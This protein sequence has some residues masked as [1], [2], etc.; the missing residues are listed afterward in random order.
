MTRQVARALRAATHRIQFDGHSFT[1]ND[2]KEMWMCTDG[3]HVVCTHEHDSMWQYWKRE[4]EGGWRPVGAYETIISAQK[5]AQATEDNAEPAQE[6]T[7]GPG[8]YVLARFKGRE[9]WMRT[10]ILTKDGVQKMI[11]IYDRMGCEVTLEQI[12]EDEVA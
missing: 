11:D 4:S 8:T 5:A 7:T 10:R 3:I 2:L 6:Q 1:Y 12:D 9:R